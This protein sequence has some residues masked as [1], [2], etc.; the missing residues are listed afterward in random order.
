MTTL[1]SDQKFLRPNDSDAR[2]LIVEGSQND[3]RVIYRLLSQSPI[4]LA[5]STASN[6]AEAMEQIDRGQT[7]KSSSPDL[8]IL[9]F[10]L[11]GSDAPRL[12]TQMRRD[13][14]HKALPVVVLTR[15]TDPGAIRRAYDFGANAVISK[16]E[17]QEGMGEIVRTIVDFWFKVADRYL[18][19]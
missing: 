9:D 17:T 18:L 1:D 10:D 13:P 6:A 4:S 12:L 15:G 8:V 19:D 14:R 5:I 11:P 2:I 3:L 7:D 16:P